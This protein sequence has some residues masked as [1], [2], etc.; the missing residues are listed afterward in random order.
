M[1]KKIGCPRGIVRDLRERP[2]NHGRYRSY[3]K[4]DASLDR[5]GIKKLPHEG[6]RKTC[7]FRG[8]IVERT[9]AWQ[10]GSRKFGKQTKR[11]TFIRR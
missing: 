2:G 10:I 8:E 11:E 4:R 6:P 1:S 3:Q 7:H 9:V 5:G